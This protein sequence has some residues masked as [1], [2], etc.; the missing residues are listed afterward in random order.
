[1][2]RYCW[3]GALI[4]AACG[5]SSSDEGDGT[6]GMTSA[7]ANDASADPASS[8]NG[9][10]SA[11]STTNAS[12]T[13]TDDP[14]VADSTGGDPTTGGDPSADCGA[15]LFTEPFEDTDFA[16]RGWYDGPQAIL[17]NVEAIDGSNASFECRFAP[18]ATGCE[19][20]TPGRHLFE[21]QTAVCLSF[22]VKYSASYV[23]SGQPYHPHEFHFITNQDDMFVGPA[24]THLTT[25]I[26]QVGGVPRLAIQ[27]TLNVDTACVL[28][29]DDSFVGCNGD[30]D[31]YPFTEMRSAAACNG[32]LGDLEGRDCFDTGNGWYSA[33]F[34]D[35]D[36]QVFGDT[37]PW[38][39]NEWHRVQTYWRLNDI[40][41]GIGVPNGV[42]RY[43]VDGELVIERD[44]V[45]MRTGAHP[46]MAFDQ[47]L[48][49]PYI[50]DGSPVDQTM[51]VDDLE[52]AA[53]MP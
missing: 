35:A 32:I 50:G 5:D 3:L 29:N 7:A 9:P 34:V 18:G 47:F 23:G 27:D 1:M 44:E 37:P 10:T 6:T 20:G 30:F 26:E 38:D 13:T 25:Y 41:N 2:R 22:W 49:A 45:L 11:S 42:I 15:V 31:T 53:G 28:R 17:S 39:K 33:R 12:E 24:A 36:L 21:A 16:A 8:S 40:E 4:L 43:W 14:T 19:G 48:V 52:V 46:D 51:W